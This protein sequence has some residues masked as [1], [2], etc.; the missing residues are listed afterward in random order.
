MPKMSSGYCWFRGEIWNL[1][2]DCKNCEQDPCPHWCIEFVSC[3]MEEVLEKV[4]ASVKTPT[5]AD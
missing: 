5:G 1:I 2:H 3:Q 4:L